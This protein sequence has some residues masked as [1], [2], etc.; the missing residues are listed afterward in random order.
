MLKG[1]ELPVQECSLKHCLEYKALE[2][3]WQFSDWGSKLPV[4]GAQ[5]WFLIREL[6]SYMPWHNQPPSPTKKEHLRHWRQP[7][8]PSRGDRY[9]TSWISV[10]LK[11]FYFCHMCAYGQGTFN[12]PKTLVS[13]LRKIRGPAPRGVLEQSAQHSTSYTVR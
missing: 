10:R 12:F 7:E 3:A 5:V 6:R 4:S 2:N 1:T 11:T 13:S 8:S 9:T